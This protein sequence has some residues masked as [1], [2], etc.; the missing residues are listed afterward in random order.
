VIDPA[1][2][3]R[4][5]KAGVAYIESLMRAARGHWDM[6]WIVEHTRRYALAL[7]ALSAWPKTI[8]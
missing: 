6:A 2:C 3:D 8:S 1:E 5:Y 7:T 4:E